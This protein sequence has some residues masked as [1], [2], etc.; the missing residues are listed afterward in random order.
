[1][2]IGIIA[3]IHGN[4]YALNEVLKRFDDEKIDKIIIV[5]D[6][7][8]IGPCSEEVM[9]IIINNYNNNKV[10][11]VNGN[12]EHYYIDGL[13]EVVHGNRKLSQEEIDNHKWTANSLSLYTKTFLESIKDTEIISLFNKRIFINHYPIK[14]DRKFIEKPSYSECNCLFE[15]NKCD[16]IIYGHTHKSNV[17]NGKKMFI[18]P[19][20]LGVL[21]ANK[22]GEYAILTI[23]EDSIDCQ[24][25][26]IKYN[27]NDLI[28]KIRE[29]KYPM[30]EKI[31]NIFYS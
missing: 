5:G 30:S 16:I 26:E 8:G 3:D 27:V 7:I 6:M 25:M 1:M 10:I 23:A 31:L 19:G 9:Q 17:V 13:P 12:H 29:L 15:H 22:N 18:N 24:I 4:I 20:S 28:Y 11:I 2:K 21:N 14:K